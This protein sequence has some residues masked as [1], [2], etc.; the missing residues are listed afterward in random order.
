ME[1]EIKKEEA[2]FMC[3]KNEYFFQNSEIAAVDGSDYQ[4]KP[5]DL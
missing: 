5:A 3:M 4:K 2:T 1:R